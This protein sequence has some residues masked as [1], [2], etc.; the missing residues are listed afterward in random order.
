MA[1]SFRSPDGALSAFTRIFNALWRNPGSSTKGGGV[2]ALRVAPW[3]VATR[4]NSLMPVYNRTLLLMVMRV[5]IGP[6]EHVRAAGLVG[7]VFPGPPS[8]GRIGTIAAIAGV[9]LALPEIFD[10]AAQLLGA[11]EGTRIARQIDRNPYHF[12]QR[13]AG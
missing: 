5:C 13:A 10:L 8:L 11:Q 2:P 12:D 1:L 7:P 3:R 6:G 4:V 9:D